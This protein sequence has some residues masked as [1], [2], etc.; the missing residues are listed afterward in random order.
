MQLLFF[1]PKPRYSLIAR[2]EDGPRDQKRY[3]LIESHDWMRPPGRQEKQWT[4][5]GVFVEQEGSEPIRLVNRMHHVP[6][7]RLRPVDRVQFVPQFAP[8]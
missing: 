3:L 8:A 6:Q 2:L 1:R 5:T 4:Y 7:D